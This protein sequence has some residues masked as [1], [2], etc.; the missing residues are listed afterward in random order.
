MKII[1]TFLYVL[2][3]SLFLPVLS[4][5]KTN[6]LVAKYDRDSRKYRIAIEDRLFTIEN[7]EDGLEYESSILVKND[8]GKIL[9]LSLTDVNSLLSDHRLYD[10]SKIIFKDE[11]NVYYEGD[12]DNAKFHFTLYPNAEKL[13]KIT[14]R[15]DDL[16]HLPDNSMMGAKMHSEFIFVGTFENEKWT[17]SVIASGYKPSPVGPGV[18]IGEATSSTLERNS[19]DETAPTVTV[20]IPKTGDDFPIVQ[21]I[22]LLTVSTGAYVFMKRRKQN[23]SQ[24]NEKDSSI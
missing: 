8:S 5:A 24:S 11:K 18:L 19:S 14:Y 4:Y 23:E 17:S 9:T 6:E 1:K 21:L 22:L 3:F 12:M 20:K 15:I 2:L 7:L 16:P 13:L 10:L